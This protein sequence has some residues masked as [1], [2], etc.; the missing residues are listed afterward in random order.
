[1]SVKKYR[2]IVIVMISPCNFNVEIYSWTR[3]ATECSGTRSQYLRFNTICAWGLCGDGVGVGG[4][5]MV[6]APRP[7]RSRL[8][9]WF[10]A[11]VLGAQTRRLERFQP[12]QNLG[13]DKRK[14]QHFPFYSTTPSP[15]DCKTKLASLISH[16]AA[17][18]FQIHRMAFYLVYSSFTEWK[19]CRFLLSNVR[20]Y[21]EQWIHTATRP[22]LLLRRSTSA[23]SSG[24]NIFEDS[25]GEI[26]F[27]QS[28]R[29][30]IHSRPASLVFRVTE[31][32]N[33]SAT[34]TNFECLHRAKWWR[35]AAS[36]NTFLPHCNQRQLLAVTTTTTRFTFQLL[37]RIILEPRIPYVEHL[38][39]GNSSVDGCV[40]IGGW[41][42]SVVNDQHVVHLLAIGGWML[43]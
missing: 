32:T 24:L 41:R 38:G 10:L 40:R 4:L 37:W 33:I 29:I 27:N 39:V 6:H 36:N 22:L 23:Q 8:H 30:C 26:L 34:A 18:H 43:L 21:D 28:R 13:C 11:V 5:S 7:K 3:K 1:M 14:A 12:Q 15:D 19:S 9:S 17:H 20:S 42:G 31:R 16:I 2:W 25:D 35:V